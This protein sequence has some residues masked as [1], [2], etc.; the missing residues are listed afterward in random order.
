MTNKTIY[1]MNRWATLAVSLLVCLAT[2]RIVDTYRHVSQVYDEP[3]HVLRGIHWQTGHEYIHSEHP[4]LGPLVFA[5]LP[6][7]QGVVF[8]DTGNKLNDGNSI[9]YGNG[10]YLRTITLF[11]LGNLLFFWI[12]CA[13]L[14]SWLVSNGRMVEGVLAVAFFS[15][16]P[17]VLAHSGVSTTDMPIT[18]MLTS[19]VFFV[20]IALCKQTVMRW[21]LAGTASGMALLAKFSAVLFLPMCVIVLLCTKWNGSKI[22]KNKSVWYCLTYIG[23]A[24]LVVWSVYGF[25]VGQMSSIQVK[26]YPFDG[27]PKRLGGARIPAPEFVA[28]LIW[29]K[30]KLDAGHGNY[31]FGDVPMGG[32]LLY[33]PTV[34][35]I[36]TSLAMLVCASVG[37]C[38]AIC[39]MWKKGG[40]WPTTPFCIFVILLVAATFSSV[41]I[42]VRHVLPL[43]PFVSALAAEGITCVVACLWRDRRIVVAACLATLVGSWLV[44]DSCRSHPYYLS[45]F[46]ELAFGVP[47]RIVIDSDIDWGQGL[48]ELE[49]KCKELNILRLQVEYFGTGKLNEHTL[50]QP[51]AENE[52]YWIAISLTL[53]YGNPE[54]ASYRSRVPDGI[55]PGGSIRLFRSIQH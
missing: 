49:K 45:H 17:P 15:F 33:F 38:V 21:M 40:T 43:Y 18:A 5:M 52:T 39:T 44:L 28:G 51:M 14:Y 27:F 16:S 24:F 34:L 13:A 22:S 3:F 35:A 4:P 19:A 53:L 46:N 2:F 23:T 25:S 54:F 26:E 41:N 1:Q 9:L 50:P 7:S 55:V 42:G 29:A 11:R 31:F 20:D 37:S 30:G 48:F 8:D 10:N 47:E 6:Y 36:K 32:S 12:A